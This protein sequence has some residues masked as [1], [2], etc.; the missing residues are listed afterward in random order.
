ML[1]M[2]KLTRWDNIDIEPVDEQKRFVMV[3]PS[4]IVDIDELPPN[5]KRNL[6]P[7]T[8]VTSI[9]PLAG[10]SVVF[11][12]ESVAEI[13]EL[14]LKLQKKQKALMK[15]N[16]ENMAEQKE[17]LKWQHRIAEDNKD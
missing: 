2:I 13:E 9:I 12:K 17:L 7:R 15:I 3:H 14:A 4:F 11:V 8:Q 6:G 10:I 16:R 1:N 5:S